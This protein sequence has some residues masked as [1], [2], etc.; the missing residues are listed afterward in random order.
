MIKQ[1]VMSSIKC[2]HILGFSLAVFGGTAIAQTCNPNIF[3]NTPDSRYE[4]VSGSNGSEVLDKQT[5][6]IWQRCSY[7]QIWNGSICTG[8]AS[9][10]KWSDALAK[11][12]SI[13]NGYRIP[14]I[15]ELES[16][17]NESCYNP[18]INSKIFPN[19]PLI[20]YGNWSS[21]LFQDRNT[22]YSWG[23]VFKYGG[24]GE[25]RGE[26]AYIRAVRSQVPE[27][28]RTKDQATTI[29][30]VQYT[31][32]KTDTTLFV[33]VNDAGISDSD[34]VANVVYKMFGSPE[35]CN[36][37][38]FYTDREYIAENNQF[39]IEIPADSC[40]Y[41]YYLYAEADVLNICTRISIG[42]DGKS[43]TTTSRT[44]IHKR[45]KVYELKDAQDKLLTSDPFGVIVN[46]PNTCL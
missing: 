7:G 5:K 45:S 40:G 14:N 24:A 10:H 2:S 39:S 46:V 22:S 11:V 9:L 44:A 25:L 6:L 12:K 13:G 35:P 31:K 8:D 30:G 28:T 4:I 41:S 29:S 20:E 34:G 36:S 15:K 38:T 3:N 1:N 42:A 33:S 17:V 43:I 19:M 18:A 21:S 23:V 32:S 16:L 26:S 37:R 27:A